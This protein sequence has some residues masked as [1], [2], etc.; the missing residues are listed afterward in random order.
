MNESLLAGMT[1]LVVEDEYLIALE[2]QRMIEEAGAEAV[3][4]ASSIAEVRKLL[5]DGPRIDA[6]VLDLRLGK[7]DA[8]P[9]IGAFGES[10]IP[11]L[12]AT[13]FDTGAPE[14]IPRLSKPYR[15]TELVEAISRLMG[16][17]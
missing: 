3:L 16:K 8:T 12:V 1:V 2:A 4:L 11:L 17:D 7:D 6:V 13:G 15:E 9:L 10:G 5:A 14:D